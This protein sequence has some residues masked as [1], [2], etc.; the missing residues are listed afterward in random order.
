VHIPFF[1]IKKSSSDHPDFAIKAALEMTEWNDEE[2][3]QVVKRYEVTWRI[4]E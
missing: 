1:K 3:F 2:G 4:E